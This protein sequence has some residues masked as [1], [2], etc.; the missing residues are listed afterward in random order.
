MPKFTCIQYNSYGSF[1]QSLTGTGHQDHEKMGCT[2]LC[3]AFTVQ[4]I[5]EL[6]W[7]LYFG[8]VSV[9]VPGPFPVNGSFTLHGTGTRTGNGMDTIENNGFK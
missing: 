3:L 1:R 7:D 8:I 6:K 5:W 4:V 9:L 2:I